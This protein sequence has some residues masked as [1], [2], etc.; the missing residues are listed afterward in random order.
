M[1]VGISLLSRIQAE[2]YV[3]SY[4]LTVPGRH[5]WFLTYLVLDKRQCLD[6]SSRVDL[7][8]KHRYSRWNVVAIICT[9]WNIRYFISTSAFRPPSF[10]FHPPWLRP[11]LTLVPLCCSMQKI[12]GFRWNFILSAMSGLSVS[13]ITSAILISG[14][15]RIALCSRQCCYQQRWLR[16]HQNKHSN[17]EFAAKSDLRTVIQWS[18]SLSDFHQKI[19]HTTFTSGDVIR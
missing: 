5:L 18:P 2:T 13:V 12:C 10:I 14:W 15:T 7:H 6:Q 1:A 3:I 11:V 8:R 9:S 16:H 19:V 4:P 17:V